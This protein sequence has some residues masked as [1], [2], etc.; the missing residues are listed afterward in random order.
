MFQKNSNISVIAVTDS[1]FV[2]RQSVLQFCGSG[3]VC[4]LKHQAKEPW[5]VWNGYKSLLPAAPHKKINGDELA[6]NRI[7]SLHSG[8]KKN[9]NIIFTCKLQLSIIKGKK[10]SGFDGNSQPCHA[11]TGWQLCTTNIAVRP[12]VRSGA[13]LK[14][15]FVPLK[16]V[17][18][19][20]VN[21]T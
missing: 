8:R 3:F 21:M 7:V 11:D 18:S 6:S 14:G 12:Q 4:P 15:S 2:L 13:N 9:H 10:F 5:E 17:W 16:E 20:S 1:S 19:H